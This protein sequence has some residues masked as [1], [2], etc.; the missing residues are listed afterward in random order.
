MWGW[1]CRGRPRPFAPACFSC[2]HARF[3]FCVLSIV[4]RVVR[5]QSGKSA[6]RIFYVHGRPAQ[7][8]GWAAV[9]RARARPAD[10]GRCARVVRCGMP[11]RARA[12]RG[13]C[14]ASRALLCGVVR[15]RARPA[16]AGPYGLT[17]RLWPYHGRRNYTGML[18]PAMRPR[19]H[20]VA[21]RSRARAPAG[22][23]W[24]TSR[25]VHLVNA[26]PLEVCKVFQLVGQLLGRQLLEH[27]AI[28]EI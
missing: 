2:M 13:S 5:A 1:R 11:G 23:S 4:S 8:V 7:L 20:S 12:R 24:P 15:S 27:V 19:P 9:D 28:G 25:R 10:V 17:R 6:G 18:A 16:P 3:P 14:D 26:L 21:D 22:P